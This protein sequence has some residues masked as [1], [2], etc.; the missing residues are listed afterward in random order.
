MYK[1]HYNIFS[2]L[3]FTVI[4]QQV[5]ISIKNVKTIKYVNFKTII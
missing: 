2:K 1:I 5:N 3:K 4:R